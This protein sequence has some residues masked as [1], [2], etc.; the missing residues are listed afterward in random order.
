LVLCTIDRIKTILGA[1]E[2]RQA[3]PQGGDSDLIDQLDRFGRQTGATA[4]PD[5]RRIIE[6]P[7]KLEGS[8]PAPAHSSREGRGE[9]VASNSIRLTVQ[10]LD[11]LMA[12]VSELV[13][14]GNQ[15]LELVRRHEDSDFTG[16]LQRL[17]NV[18]AKLQ[19]GVMK[20][21]MQPI[22]VAWQKLP[23]IV[24]D[25]CA[26]L[27]KDIELKMRG[28]ETELDRQVL[29]LIQ[30]P[31]MH[32]VRNCADHGIGS[33]AERLAAG[34]PEKGAIRLSAWQEGGHIIIEIADDG[35]GLD[36]ARIRAK[37]VERGLAD[38]A[39]VNARSDDEIFDFIFTPGFSTAK[40]VTS[41][42][43]RGVGMDVVRSNVEQIGGT[44]HLK[45]VRG[46]GTTVTI[47]IPLTL[48][49]VS[50]LIVETA[51]Q[52]FAIPQ[53]S[54]LELVRAGRNGEHCIERIKDTPVLRLRN[55]LLP[56]I[57]LKEALRLGEGNGEDG[58]V[59]VTQIGSQIFGIVV[60]AVFH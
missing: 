51:G 5:G 17:S 49:I 22:G 59:A 34:K 30:D 35:R 56:L 58:F 53:L 21:R 46:V 24:R 60:D 15:L 14:T 7:E 55:R 44:V 57:Y 26:E 13:L 42:S 1:I 29:E 33:A 11:H 18:T 3:E 2:A 31:L 52:R 38:E 45:T 27:G 48:A 50:A 47:R 8:E 4:Q 37:A 10:T 20:A 12:T 40:Q 41:I 28:A 32:L 54:L 25:L 19:E 23:R 16:P 6:R 9:R 39:E 36:A 43:G